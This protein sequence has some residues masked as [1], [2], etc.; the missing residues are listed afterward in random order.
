MD[1]YDEVKKI[2]FR[3][4]LVFSGKRGSVRRRISG[5]TAR[6]SLAQSNGLGLNVGE[7][8]G[9]TVRDPDQSHTY[10]Y[11]VGHSIPSQ[12]PSVFLLKRR[13]LVMLFLIAGIGD[14]H[15]AI[16]F[17]GPRAA[18]QGSGTTRRWR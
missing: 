16:A 2:D 4:F 13:L 14:A 6:D 11:V 5:P 3:F 17:Q 18:R 1:S 10:R 12:Q 8:C 9:P 15:D 7:S